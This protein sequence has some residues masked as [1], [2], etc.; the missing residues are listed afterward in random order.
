[1]IRSLEQAESSQRPISGRLKDLSLSGLYCYVTDPCPLKPG[2]AVVCS[3]EIPAEQARFFPFSWVAGKG[4]VIRI[5][6]VSVGRRAGESPSDTPL[7]GV[8]IAFASDVTSLG[9]VEW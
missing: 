4:R 1:M 9:T 5:E 7:L 6:P 8:A 2:E 3:A